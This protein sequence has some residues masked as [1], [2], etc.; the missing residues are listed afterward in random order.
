MD[1]G[2]I[3]D[4]WEKIKRERETSRREGEASRSPHAPRG[5]AVRSQDASTKSPSALEA[6]LSANEDQRGALEGREE[7]LEGSPQ[8]RADEAHRLSSLRPQ[9]ALDLHGMTAERAQAAV[10]AFIEQSA[11]S[12]LEKVLVIHGKGLHSEGSPVLKKAARRALEAQ[13]LAGRF[14]EADKRDGG[15]G[16][17]W[18]LI[19]RKR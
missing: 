2:E 5:E 19:R 3:L 15:S 11:R 18:V 10:W 14:G 7:E 6:W 16:A 8:E 9:A 17:L 12:G 13:P 1:F 4:E